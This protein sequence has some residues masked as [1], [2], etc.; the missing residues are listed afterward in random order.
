MQ[1]KTEVTRA[2]FSAVLARK[3]LPGARSCTSP[4]FTGGDAAAKTPAKRTKTA[5]T[6]INIDRI[7]VRNSGREN[8]P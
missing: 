2:A 5:F 1:G 4:A 7:R 8:I 3:T 6:R